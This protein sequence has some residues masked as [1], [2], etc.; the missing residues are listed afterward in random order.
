MFDTEPLLLI[1]H[2]EPKIRKFH[3]FRQET[4][5]SNQNIDLAFFKFFQ[6]F[7]LLSTT[8]ETTQDID[9]YWKGLEAFFK[10]GIVLLS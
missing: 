6:S 9:F 1:N 8:P 7:F 10:I 5:G 3:I 4:V 2:D